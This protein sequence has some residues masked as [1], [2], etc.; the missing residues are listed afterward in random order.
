[1]MELAEWAGSRLRAFLV[2]TVLVDASFR[3]ARSVGSH[4]S[5]KLAYSARAT[6]AGAFHT[7]SNIYSERCI[8][9]L[10]YGKVV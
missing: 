6:V 1:M 9:C 10:Y 8:L 4:I 7:C 5:I 3:V 2:G